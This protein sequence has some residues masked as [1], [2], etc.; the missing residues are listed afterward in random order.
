MINAGCVE[1]HED[2][3]SSALVAVNTNVE[4]AWSSCMFLAEC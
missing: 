3:L 1:V 4:E 2:I